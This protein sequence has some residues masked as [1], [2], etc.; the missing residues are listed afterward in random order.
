MP[1]CVS[2]LAASEL[3]SIAE[4]LDDAGVSAVHELV[5]LIKRKRV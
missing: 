5:G 1:L 4:N 3:L 2:Y